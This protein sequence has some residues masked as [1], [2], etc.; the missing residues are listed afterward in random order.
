VGIVTG[1]EAL[2]MRVGFVGRMGQPVCANLVRAGYMVTAGA[3]RAELESIV[4][5]WGHG[6]AARAEVLITILPGTRDWEIAQRPA[7][8]PGLAG[9]DAA[10]PQTPG[11][12][13]TSPA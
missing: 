3:V 1:R 7:Q 11:T 12:L 9:L 4:A 5:G 8:T 2:R 6:G 10:K 13:A